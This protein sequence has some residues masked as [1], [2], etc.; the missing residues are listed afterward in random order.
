MH[1][2]EAKRR[3]KDAGRTNR[4]MVRVLLHMLNKPIPVAALSK[5]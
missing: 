1:F 4:W 3:M 2:G 5:E